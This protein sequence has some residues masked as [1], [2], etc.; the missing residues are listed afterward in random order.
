M[1]AKQLEDAFK[2]ASKLPPKEQE[3]LGSWL[4]SELRSDKRWTDS[5]RRTEEGLS[6]LADEALGEHKDDLS[7]ELDPD[8]L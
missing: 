6:H 8:R 2:E 4:L 1:T 7:E 3:S 5:F